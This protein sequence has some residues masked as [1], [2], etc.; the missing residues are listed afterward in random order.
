M[1]GDPSAKS[2]SQ[3]LNDARIER[4]PERSGAGAGA[5]YGSHHGHHYRNV[6]LKA[7]T[8]LGVR[9]DRSVILASR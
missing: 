3:S 4:S 8:Q 6:T 1:R 2:Y 5:L 7:G 9:L